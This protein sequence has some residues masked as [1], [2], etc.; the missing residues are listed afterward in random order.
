MRAWFVVPL[1]VLAVSVVAC[2]GGNGGRVEAR[3]ACLA[4]VAR[5][6]EMPPDAVDLDGVASAVELDDGWGFS[7]VVAAPTGERMLVCTYV[8]GKADVTLGNPV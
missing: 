3:N 6:A 2:G 5:L 8:D 1:V 7:G 4:E